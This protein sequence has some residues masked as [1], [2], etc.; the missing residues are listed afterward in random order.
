M[1]TLLVTI[2][3]IT[4]LLAAERPKPNVLFI[5][6]DD[7]NTHVTT[8]GYSPI[9][10][11][12][13]DSL[14]AA[15]LNLTRAY[16]QYPVCNP[17]RTSILSGLYPE[18]TGVISNDAD[19]RQTRP[20]T[21]TM[22]RFFRDAGYWTARTGKVF[23][24]PATNPAEAWDENPDRFEND[25]MPVDK[26]AREKFEAEHGPINNPKNRKAWK[27]LLPTIATQT[28][29]EKMPGYGPSGLRD[30]QHKDGKNARQVATWLNE[31]SYDQK[32]FFIACGIQK[33]HVPFLAP[34]KYFDMY[35]KEKLVFKPTRPDFWKQAPAIA[36]SGRYKEFGF[37]LGIE[38][39]ALR[40]EYTQAYHACISFIDAQIAHVLDAVRKN[41]LW[42]NT[43]I[44][45][46][47][48]H[49]YQLGEHFMWGKVTLFE[50]CARVPLI[51][52]APATNRIGKSSELVELVDLFPTLASL[53][54]L[55]APP[56]V[57]GRSFVPLLID[58]S[59]KG[60]DA[61][62]TVVSRGKQLGRSIRTERWRYARWPRGGE[63]LYDLIKDPAEETNLASMPEHRELL[64]SLRA[65][66][67]K[68]EATAAAK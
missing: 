3:A 28:R 64:I 38:N 25:E 29:G 10:T 41:G 40:R 30:E 65:K 4:P 33:P 7:L 34:D 51:I 55:D 66:L 23:H 15:G 58:P 52:R 47:S 12:A 63:E 36:Q 19:L 68:A 26:A 13:F 46:T 31:K 53:C 2:A 35:P 1:K 18:S 24:N 45:L 9:H 16:C 50:E 44:V 21:I 62:Y 37:T 8:S 32:P 49:G 17:S 42:D 61:A 59:A 57:Q 43:I 60:R 14:A 27:E 67:S 6:C 22:P 56:H 39:D 11:P 20:G 48:D 54:S 5:I